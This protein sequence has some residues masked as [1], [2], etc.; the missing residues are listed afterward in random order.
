MDLWP[1]VP[2][3]LPD[4][5]ANGDAHVRT[6]GGTVSPTSPQ[7]S[8]R[9]SPSSCNPVPSEPD[10]DP[11]GGA[12]SRPYVCPH[13]EPHGGKPCMPPT[14]RLSTRSHRSAR[15]QTPTEEPTAS[16]TAAPTDEPTAVRSHYAM[17]QA[18]RIQGSLTQRDLACDRLPRLN[19]PRPPRLAPPWSLASPPRR[20]HPTL[21]LR[22]PRYV[23]T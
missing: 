15:A 13:V 3:G 22:L 21:L 23:G 14:L 19:R 9:P 7:A 11:H 4:G 10:L 2:H 5:G 6:H 1:T 8:L 16:P 20:P 12:H 18:P 17:L